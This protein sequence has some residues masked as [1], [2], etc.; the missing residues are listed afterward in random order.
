MES[1]K[2][3][4]TSQEMQADLE[5]NI[6]DAISILP[7]M[8]YGLDVNVRFRNPKDFEYTP[9]CVLF[10]LVDIDLVHGWILDPQTTNALEEELYQF[11][12]ELSY[13]QLMEKL[14]A[15][16]AVLEVQPKPQEN[17]TLSITQISVTE[18]VSNENESVSVTTQ[19][20]EVTSNN[21][22]NQPTKQTSKSPVTPKKH[23]SDNLD[24][25]VVQTT[26]NTFM[27]SNKNMTAEETEKIIK[28]GQLAEK[29]LQ[30][31]PSQLTFHGITELHKTLKDNQLCV[32]FRNNHFA[33]LFKYKGNL[34]VLITDSGFKN[35]PV[36]W[37]KLDMVDN[38]TI[39]YKDDFT[40][41]KGSFLHPLLENAVNAVSDT[42]S[43]LL[44]IIETGNGTVPTDTEKKLMASTELNVDY[45][46][47]DT[48]IQ[49]QLLIE[50]RILLQRKEEEEQRDRELALQ[51]HEQELRDS[52]K[53]RKDSSA[54]KPSKEK[55]KLKTS[56]ENKKEKDKDCVVM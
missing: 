7:K 43:N 52:Q 36:V 31:T 53:R 54:K 32:F 20:T 19:I 16:S 15:M 4:R 33:T 2:S 42:I 35:E 50:Q 9:E 18:E 48:E 46:P 45:Q 41:F 55:E 37:E 13:N 56:S 11:I 29:W 26:M 1:N 6:H 22:N 30:D 49:Q 47:D 14:I 21:D 23:W 27:E 12:S 28:E 38:D 5:K 24:P 3:I 51:L 8:Q 40:E 44:P 34:Y 10:D 17:K 39:F 25:K